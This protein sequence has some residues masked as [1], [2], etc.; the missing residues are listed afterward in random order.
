[1]GFKTMPLDHYLVFRNVTRYA[2][3][4]REE[5]Y[6]VLGFI[7][8]KSVGSRSV[9][10][11]LV[12][13][14]P[15]QVCTGKVFREKVATL[16]KTN[17]RDCGIPQ[18]SPI[19]DVLANLYLLE[20]DTWM[21]NEM[22]KIGGSYRR[23]SDDILMIVPGHADDFELRLSEIEKRLTAYGD[24]LKIQPA[25]STVHKFSRSADSEFQNYQLVSGSAG[26]NGLD[27]LGFRFDGRKIFIRDSTRSRLQR[28]MTFAVN[29]TVRRLSRA[30][31]GKGRAELK[32]LFDANVVLSQFYKVRDFETVAAIPNKWTFWTYL[33]RAQKTFGMKGKSI[34]GQVRNFRRSISY[35]ADKQIDKYTIIP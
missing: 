29:A 24:K 32:R 19:S 10:G 28:K 25:K 27:Y 14:V 31:P 20:F 2:S 6:K 3:V 8:K 17:T 26:K 34:A 7:G 16:V 1:M 11:Y 21:T 12:S 22:A 18:G 4:N 5:L 15:L 35:K 30:N 9:I 13:R 23:Y 33:I